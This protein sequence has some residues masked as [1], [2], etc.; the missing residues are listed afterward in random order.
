M[1]NTGEMKP[2]VQHV[3]EHGSDDSSR[4]F[5]VRRGSFLLSPEDDIFPYKVGSISNQDVGETSYALIDEPY[6]EIP[7][8]TRRGSF[9]L[10]GDEVAGLAGMINTGEMKPSVQHVV[11]HGSDDHSKRRMDVRR[12]SFMIVDDTSPSKAGNSEGAQRSA[13]QRGHLSSSDEFM[14]ESRYARGIDVR[15]GS[16]VFVPDTEASPKEEQ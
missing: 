6:K 3:V 15:R 14:A 1:I 11:E 12:G 4:K 5:T 10:D 13:L 7:F 8:Q 16:F 2:S 9:L